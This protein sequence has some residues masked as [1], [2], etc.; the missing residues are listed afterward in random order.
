MR[1][2]LR[3]RE[4]PATHEL[5]FRVEKLHLG[6]VDGSEEAEARRLVPRASR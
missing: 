2:R 5:D 6:F 3:G 1:K 4:L